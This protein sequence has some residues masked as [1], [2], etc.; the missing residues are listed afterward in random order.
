MVDKVRVLLSLK[1]T[2]DTNIEFGSNEETDAC[3]IQ[4]RFVLNR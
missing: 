1:T 2:I 4:D 3:T